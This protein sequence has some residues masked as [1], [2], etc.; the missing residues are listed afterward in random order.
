MRRELTSHLIR[1]QR[2]FFFHFFI[3]SFFSS[4]SLHP[5]PPP[6]P[7]PP[8]LSPSSP[9]EVIQFRLPQPPQPNPGP[10]LPRN[11]SH[12]QH[13]L[14]FVFFL[15]GK[16]MRTGR[17]R[18]RKEKKSLLEW[19]YFSM[20]HQIR[21]GEGEKWNKLFVSLLLQCCQIHNAKI[22]AK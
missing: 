1:V 15:C 8:P 19:C 21:K 9:P 20:Q 2:P 10:T 6:P 3:I 16:R 18:R 12:T 22:M 5:P 4:I 14:L 17:R 11:P 7:P 13:F